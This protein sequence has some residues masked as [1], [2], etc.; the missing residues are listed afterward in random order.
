MTD[1]KQPTPYKFNQLSKS[2]HTQK[3][4]VFNTRNTRAHSKHMLEFDY[5]NDLDSEELDW[6]ADFLLAELHQSPQSEMFQEMTPEERSR[7]YAE[8]YA[9]QVDVL[10]APTNLQQCT[11][12][13]EQ[14]PTSY[15]FHDM[16]EAEVIGDYILA[17]HNRPSTK[18]SEI[19]DMKAV[20]AYLEEN[21]DQAVNEP[22]V[23]QWLKLAHARKDR[24]YKSS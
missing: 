14:Y 9:R 2:K 5:L 24:K 23:Q 22:A 19:A 10:T 18:L 17:Q 7:I 6:L 13:I 11:K 16:D 8:H 15:P 3:T 20:I 1:P 21:I 4:W 12:G